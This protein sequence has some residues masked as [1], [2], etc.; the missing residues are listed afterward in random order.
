MIGAVTLTNAILCIPTGFLLF[1]ISHKTLAL[2]GQLIIVVAC[3]IFAA[4]T[5]IKDDDTFFIIG[6]ISRL[7]IG[8]GSAIYNV[9]S[10]AILTIEFEEI[11]SQMLF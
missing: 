1:Y 4:T 3:F 7:S 8:I 10:L 9:A 5:W 6:Y 11:R 2:T